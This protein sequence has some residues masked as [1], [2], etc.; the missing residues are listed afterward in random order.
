M[1]MV[2]AMIAA[3]AALGLAGDSPAPQAEGQPVLV[4]QHVWE[5]RRPGQGRAGEP[6]VPEPAAF[7]PEEFPD[8]IGQ[9]G[10]VITAEAAEKSAPRRRYPRGDDQ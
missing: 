10:R 9:D 8:L 5:P 7:S 2:S 1:V 4:A 6:A 3:A